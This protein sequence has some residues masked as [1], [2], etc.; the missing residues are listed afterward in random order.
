MTALLPPLHW[1]NPQNELGLRPGYWRLRKSG[2][3]IFADGYLDPA[4]DWIQ[5]VLGPRDYWILCIKAYELLTRAC[6]LQLSR[7]IELSAQE[8]SQTSPHGFAG[9]N[10]LSAK[11]LAVHFPKL[12]WPTVE[13]LSTGKENFEPALN[14][15]VAPRDASGI[16]W[17]LWCQEW[18]RAASIHSPSFQESLRDPSRLIQSSYQWICG[19]LKSGERNLDEFSAAL[20]ALGLGALGAFPRVECELC[21][22]LAIC[23]RLRCQYHS[24]SSLVQDDGDTK[25]IQNSAKARRTCVHLG[26]PIK[27]PT[28]YVPGSAGNEEEVV[29]G[30]L[31]QL[32]GKSLHDATKWLTSVLT[33]CPNVALHLPEN[34]LNLDANQILLHLRSCL[35]DLEWNNM[36]WV[37]KIFVAEIWLAGLKT[38]APDRRRIISKLNLERFRRAMALIEDGM[39]K[40]EVA[41]ALGVS[42]SNLTNIIHAGELEMLQQHK[43]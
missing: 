25:N 9:G 38:V 31:W 23:Q 19:I 15:K 40:S 22:R 17:N 21:F 1:V 32:N 13:G 2:K 5:G 20:T 7:D 11:D 29:C 6:D 10:W 3:S 42:R 36:T 4:L 26:W 12:Q 8:L 41:V 33:Q 34:I 14:L 18:Q 35:D 39:K 43:N 24:V 16:G 27:K 37:G 28:Y 30:L